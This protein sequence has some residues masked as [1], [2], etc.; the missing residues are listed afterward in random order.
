MQLTFDDHNK[1]NELVA[2]T[3]YELGIQGI[4]LLNDHPELEE[5]CKMLLKYNQIIGN[6]TKSHRAMTRFTEEDFKEEVIDFQTKLEGFAG[7]VE[8]F[9]YPY[10]QRPNDSLVGKLKDIFPNILRGVEVIEGAE[11]NTGDILRLPVKL[12]NFKDDVILQCH[13]VTGDNPCDIDQQLW[14]KVLATLQQ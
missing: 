7:K 8:W 10:S 11:N 12:W 4:F 1:S 6:H 5:E 9:S 13:G 3:L 2:K 14:E